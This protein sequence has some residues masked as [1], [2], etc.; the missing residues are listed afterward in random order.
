[1]TI[2]LFSLG[3][4]AQNEGNI[5]YFGNGAGIDFSSGLPVALTNGALH[6]MEGCASICDQQGQILFYTDGDT[7]WN[8]N[9]Q[10]MPNGTGLLG[11][12]SST[13]SALIVQSPGS[14][15]EYYVFTADEGSL[16]QAGVNYSIV[17]MTLDNGMGDVT[18]IKNVNVLSATFE[19]LI[20]IKH[21]NGVDVWI[22]M[23][24]FNTHNIHAYLLTASGLSTTPVVY[25]TGGSHLYPMGC[26]KA[27]PDGK[28]VAI[29]NMTALGVWVG[30]VRCYD[31]NNL[32]GVLSNEI[33]L[34]HV[35]GYGLEF[36]PNSDLLY[37][38]H[39]NAGGYGCAQYNLNM[40]PPVVAMMV[41]IHPTKQPGTIQLAP[42]GKIYTTHLLEDSLSVIHHPDSLGL[43]CDFRESDFYLGGKQ[44]TFGLP[45][46]V[47]TV[48]VPKFY[49]QNFCFGDSTCFFG[50]I[51]ATNVL[52]DFGDPTSGVNNQ[53]TLLNPKHLFSDTGYFQVS[54]YITNGSTTDTLTDSVYI[55]PT[56]SFSL[57]DDT[58]L[59]A[60]ESLLLGGFSIP[61]ATYLW[62]DSSTFYTYNVTQSG[63]YWVDVDVKGC[64]VTDT[65]NVNYSPSDSA[66][67]NYNTAYCETDSNAI[68]T[69]SGIS[70]G[71][72]S[73]TNLGLI[74]S[75]SGQVD[76]S[77][78]GPGTYIVTYT[79]NGY[80]PISTTD[81]III[82][83][84][85]DATILLTGPYCEEDNP[86]SLSAA[87]QG[88]TWSGSGVTDSQTGVFDPGVATLGNNT[89]IY[90]INGVC[91][92]SDTAII[93]V[94]PSPIITAR[95]DTII[96][97]GESV[98]LYASGSSG[99][100]DWT[101]P[102]GLSCTSCQD[103][104]ATPFQTTY[105]MI[106]VTDSNGCKSSDDVL[107]TVNYIAEIG[108]PS[109]F[110]PNGDG[111]N[112]ILYVKGEGIKS[113][114][115]FIYNRY[116]QQVFKS[117]NQKVGWD[118][119]LNGNRLNPGVFAYY[120][121]VGFHN[122]ETKQFKGNVTLKR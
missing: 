32:T 4:F 29:A 115:F 69:I 43:S 77:S 66:E 89:I 10:A 107:I 54:L 35:G 105:Y 79:T 71:T 76:L 48:M 62:Q 8:R 103:P 94:F 83:G 50:P 56:P 47:N 16:N 116:G 53:S 36:S 100:F 90:E 30:E 37:L 86:V 33:V 98:Q 91:S 87:T 119:T 52:W 81:T 101:P 120:L 82:E 67:I 78:S 57:P 70:G 60:G 113:M 45:N 5:W 21:Q 46:F 74:D 7:I 118:G 24:D 15:T 102:Y 26:L 99:N 80:C 104:I 65:I 27:S 64:N 58:T 51:T 25:V 38:I 14:S 85:P 117:Q 3:A 1:M 73:I 12:T 68:P 108:V 22:L 93:E 18:S 28:R 61:N 114:N 63:T 41:G 97:S 42:D 34:F 109:A 13:Q 95:S 39:H 106:I 19:K 44:S 9:H 122:G 84:I 6:T 49:V 31:F 11:H 121:E 59:C 112:D 92:N 110:S 88:G 72:F 96:L 20:G 40:I 23:M 17:D 75:L 55:I 111:H 2:S